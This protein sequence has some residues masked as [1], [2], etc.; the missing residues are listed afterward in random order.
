MKR[1]SPKP[2]LKLARVTGSQ[3]L[4][5]YSDLLLLL[6]MQA[7]EA[8]TVGTVFNSSEFSGAIG[9]LDIVETAIDVL[10]GRILG[11]NLDVAESQEAAVADH[12]RD[13][14]DVLI[15]DGEQTISQEAKAGL[16]PPSVENLR[17]AKAERAAFIESLQCTDEM[18][19]E[20]Q[21]ALDAAGRQ[22]AISAESKQKHL[23]RSGLS[24]RPFSPGINKAESTQSARRYNR[25]SLAALVSRRPPRW[26]CIRPALPSALHGRSRSLC[27]C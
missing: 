18:I 4:P 19:A 24:G 9:A 16:I 22:Q 11:I 21:A 5:L 27:G 2:C 14:A 15:Q 8:T 3:I 1:A 10:S 6:S 23:C 7:P 12:L 13:H 20:Q 17:E 26:R 25:P